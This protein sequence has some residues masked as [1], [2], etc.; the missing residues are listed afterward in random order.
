MQ[1]TT[2]VDDSVFFSRA[3]EASIRIGLVALLGLWCFQLARPFIT[4]AVWGVI[5]AIFCALGFF[6]VTQRDWSPNPHPFRSSGTAPGNKGPSYWEV[7]ED[8]D[9]PWRA[10][11]RGLVGAGMHIAWPRTGWAGGVREHLAATFRN[12][13]AGTIQD[14]ITE[15]EGAL[16]STRPAG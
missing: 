8:G 16:L 6:D 7:A 2:S 4:P 14:R 5:L 11:L 15:L 13:P 10:R 1:S 9:R 3:L 12:N